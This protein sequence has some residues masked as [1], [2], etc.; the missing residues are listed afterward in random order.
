MTFLILPQSFFRG[1]VFQE[2]PSITRALSLEDLAVGGKLRQREKAI[3]SRSRETLE[4]QVKL[5][6]QLETSHSFL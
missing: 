3:C 6:Q 1:K 4:L 5:P 2:E